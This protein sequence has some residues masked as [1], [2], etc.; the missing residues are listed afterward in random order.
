MRT[1][2]AEGAQG[3]ADPVISV[4]DRTLKCVERSGEKVAAIASQ[5][6]EQAA[7]VDN[8]PKVAGPARLSG[9]K[10]IRRKILS[11]LSEKQGIH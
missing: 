8:E 10:E 9:A 11:L 5:D 3:Y 1:G 2:A 7:T 4:E 6:Q